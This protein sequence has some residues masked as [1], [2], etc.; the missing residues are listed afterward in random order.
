MPILTIE[1]IRANP[2]NAISHDL[3]EHPDWLLLRLACMAADYCRHSEWDLMYAALSDEYVPPQS[4]HEP[5]A[6][7]RHEFSERLAEIADAKFRMFCELFERSN[8]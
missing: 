5:D 1:A 7:D 4:C 2:W 6:A 8:E 3:P